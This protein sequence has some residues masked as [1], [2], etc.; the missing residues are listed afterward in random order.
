MTKTNDLNRELIL[1]ELSNFEQK[2]GGDIPDLLN[3]YL[4]SIAQNGDPMFSWT[5]LQPLLRRKLEVV[6]N[7]FNHLCPTDHLIPLPN[8]KPFDFS[9]LKSQ[10]LEAID[11]FCS[12]PFTIQR[13]CELATNPSK[14]YKRTDKFMRGVEKNILV[15][16]T[17]EPLSA[18]GSNTQMT[19]SF[20]NLFSSMHSSSN[21]FQT[22]ASLSTAST[23]LLVNGIA[24]VLCDNQM[25]NESSLKNLSSGPVSPTSLPLSPTT[26]SPPN[27]HQH[28]TPLQQLDSF[29][30]VFAT[31][32]SNPLSVVYEQSSSLSLLPSL[33]SEDNCLLSTTSTNIKPIGTSGDFE[34]STNP[35]LDSSLISSTSSSLQTNSLTDINSEIKSD[36]SENI[37]NDEM[38]ETKRLESNETISSSQIKEDLPQTSCNEN[39]E[40][41]NNNINSNTS[42]ENVVLDVKA[43]T[44]SSSSS[45]SGGLDN[46][47]TISSNFESNDTIKTDTTPT[48]AE[49]FVSDMASSD[50]SVS[51]V[52]E[53]TTQSLNNNTIESTDNNNE[54][55][56]TDEEEMSQQPMDFCGSNAVTDNNMAEITD[57]SDKNSGVSA[58]CSKMDDTVSHSD[59]PEPMDED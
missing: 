27:P 16:T 10:I 24:D 1:D 58:D 39:K 47:N 4:E 15:V 25:P 2:K 3:Q 30:T 37:T 38:N 41:I 45:S 23:S 31:P 36:F 13:I 49:T 28:N 55:R 59:Q 56:T 53:V 21:A 19:S 9:E 11:G 8:V 57:L 14:H 54:M 40:M 42:E 26:N 29:T 51:L 22:T 34:T 20:K 12:A 5:K 6:M 52:P 17:M 7:E 44:S 35:D 46:N 48:L 32:P 33:A 50:E 18:N 43:V